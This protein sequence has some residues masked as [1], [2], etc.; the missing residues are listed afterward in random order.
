M[1]GDFPRTLVLMGAG[2]MGGA[3]LEGWLGGGLDGAGVTVVD[4]NASE[5]L[6]ALAARHGFRLNPDPAAIA[7]PEVLVLGVK[8]QMLDAAAPMIGALAGP[9]TLVLSILAGK[10]IADLAARAPRASAFVRAMPNLPASVRRGVTGVAANTA[11][12]GNQRLV[13]T[14]LLSGEVTFWRSVAGSSGD[15]RRSSPAPSMVPRARRSATSGGSPAAT[16]AS[17]RHSTR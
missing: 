7:E 1:T 3:M 15:W 9:G 11:V 10:T 2:K 6:K 12:D 13:A 17:A 5:A 8:P 4:P 16:P 14:A